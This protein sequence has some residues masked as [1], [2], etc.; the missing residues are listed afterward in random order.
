MDLNLRHKR[1][2]VL[3]SVPTICQQ[4]QL[5]ITANILPDITFF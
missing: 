3:I 1:V 5:P 4:V 2:N